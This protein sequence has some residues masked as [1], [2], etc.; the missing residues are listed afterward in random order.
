MKFRCKYEFR[1]LIEATSMEDAR[2]KFENLIVKEVTVNKDYIDIWEV[3][4]SDDNE[5]WW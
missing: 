3:E 5:P 1:D 2:K 4:D